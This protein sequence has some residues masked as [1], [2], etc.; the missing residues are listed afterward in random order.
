MLISEGFTRLMIRCSEVNI[1]R[2]KGSHIHLHR[3]SHPRLA[4]WCRTRSAKAHWKGQNTIMAFDFRRYKRQ[5]SEAGL[6][7]RAQREG[8]EAGL[9]GRAHRVVVRE[10]SNRNPLHN[11]VSIQLQH[12]VWKEGQHSL[13]PKTIAQAEEALGNGQILQAH[14]KTN[15]GDM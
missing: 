7:G 6:R 9:R 5:G 8:S 12:R 4:A 15:A 10:C 14:V 3:A 13:P 2:Y 11:H 1:Q